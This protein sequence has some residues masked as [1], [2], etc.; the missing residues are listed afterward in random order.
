MQDRYQCRP[1]KQ[2]FDLRK[3]GINFNGK[4][5]DQYQFSLTGSVWKVRGFC[6]E[7]LQLSSSALVAG[8]SYYLTISLSTSSRELKV[9][10]ADVTL[11][12][13]MPVV[14]CR[15]GLPEAA[16]FLDQFVDKARHS[17]L[18]RSRVVMLMSTNYDYEVSFQ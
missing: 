4:S 15:K 10:I 16:E 6:W 18:V 5:P 7:A 9:I 17:G 2:N 13:L 14:I 11:S 12:A 8:C 3:S 1:T